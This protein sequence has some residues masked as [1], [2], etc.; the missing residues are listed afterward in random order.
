ML[1][2]QTAILGASGSQATDD[3][4]IA[5]LRK[6]ADRARAAATFQAGQAVRIDRTAMPEELAALALRDLAVVVSDDGQLTTTIAVLH[7][8]G[9]PMV[10]PMMTARLAAIEAE[11]APA[12]G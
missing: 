8:N 4:I 5:A 10:V 9:T 2:I 11:E 6:H 12:N 3:E 1:T 7:A